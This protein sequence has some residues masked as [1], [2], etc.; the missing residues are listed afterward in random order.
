MFFSNINPDMNLNSMNLPARY[1]TIEEYCNSNFHL[2][3]NLSLL[4]YN[5]CSFFAHQS[6]F[7]CLLDMFPDCF[8]ILTLSETWLYPFNFQACHLKNYTGYHTYRTESRSGGISVFV[9]QIYKSSM[10]ESLSLCNE[11]IESCVVRISKNDVI[12]SCIGIYRPHSGTIEA[13]TDELERILCSSLIQNGLVF[14]SGDMNINMNFSSNMV[15]NYV[16][17]LTSLNYFSLI[18]NN[19]RFSNNDTNSNQSRS[20]IDHVWINEF[21]SCDSVII[22]YGLTDHRP[23]I[24]HLNYNRIVNTQPPLKTIEF[25]PFKESL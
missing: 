17:T 18:N 1:F 6:H 2:S 19:T 21:L 15:L 11:N 24:V 22:E 3:S 8:D 13:F 9:N 16:A 10:V 14:V 23:C 20:A 7:E 25:R 5:I 12:I 4:N